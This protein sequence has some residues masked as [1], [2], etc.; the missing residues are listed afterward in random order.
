MTLR[1]KGTRL[2]SVGHFQPD[3]VVPNSHFEKTVDAS[4]D[5]IR[6]RIGVVT[7]RLAGPDESVV[8]M[9]VKAGASCL[10][11]S[12]LEADEID[13]VV[14]ATCFSVHRLPNVASQVSARL[15]LRHPA[16]IDV[17][18]ACSGY[19]HAL[20]LAQHSVLAGASR[21]ALVI[22]AEKASDFM[23]WNDRTT[24][25]IFGDGAGAAIVTACD[26]PEMGPVVWGGD[27]EK[28]SAIRIDLTTDKFT[29][30]GQSVFRWA[31]S[32]L[33]PVALEA[34]TRAGVDPT[35]LTAFVPH[36]A[37]VRIIDAIARKIGAT[38]AVIARDVAE[39]GNTSA[40]SIPIALSKLKHSGQIRGG[41]L[42]LLLGFGGGLSYAAQVVACP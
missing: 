40:A 17:N 30:D 5:W 22:G 19:V 25:V 15:D 2:L 33:A 9:A 18:T 23:D 1:A 36:Q 24:C 26:R 12:G 41:D 34:C 27:A 13:L 3:R 39:S 21:R 7:R 8:D 38:R 10:A 37:N 28:G 35:A 42:V 20:A 11:E 6:Q 29:Q 14:V 16:A 4:D 32:A 31:T